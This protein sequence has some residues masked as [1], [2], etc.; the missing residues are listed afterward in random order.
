[1]NQGKIEKV[2]MDNIS[3]HNMKLEPRETE[4]THNMPYPS[5]IC[6]N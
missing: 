6:R 1:M 4:T 5:S 3:H 2:T